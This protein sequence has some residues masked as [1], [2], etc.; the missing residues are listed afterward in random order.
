MS[1]SLNNSFFVGIVEAG[2]A[3]GAAASLAV[4][5]AVATGARAIVG[6]GGFSVVTGG[7]V[8]SSSSGFGSMS[9]WMEAVVLV[10]SFVIFESG[11]GDS[12]SRQHEETSI[13]TT[14]GCDFS[15]SGSESDEGCGSF[16]MPPSI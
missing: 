2:G 12:G 13:S 14:T 16:G 4:A 1:L 15:V 10:A 6:S 5:G 3:V 8:R 9:S 7:F 11:C